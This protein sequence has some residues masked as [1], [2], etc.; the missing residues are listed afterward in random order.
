MKKILL[1]IFSLMIIAGCQN[2]SEFRKIKI[3]NQDLRVQIADEALEM[4]KGLS[5]RKSLPADEGMLFIYPD[6]RRPGVWMK[7]M[8]FPLDLIWIK[9]DK[10][11]D[12]TTNVPV[13]T[14]TPLLHY[15]PKEPINYVLEVNA[16][17]VQTNKIKIGD[18]V[19][20]DKN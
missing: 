14:T 11:V 20:F 15:W 9:N 12:I 4:A 18:Q 8:Q 13:P 16:G 10:I 1:L 17:F 19:D 7:E 6:Y 2:N 3:G 5:G